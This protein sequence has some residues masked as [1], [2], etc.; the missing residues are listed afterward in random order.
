MAKVAT[1]TKRTCHGVLIPSAYLD[2]KVYCLN[3]DKAHWLDD[4]GYEALT[5]SECEVEWVRETKRGR[6]PSTCPDC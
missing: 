6:K 1:C 3:P 5:C 2:G 4:D